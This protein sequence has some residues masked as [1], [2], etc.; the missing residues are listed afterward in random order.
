[1]ELEIRLEK[2][3]WRQIVDA[4]ECQ[5]VVY[6]DLLFPGESLKF[7]ITGITGSDRKCQQRPVIIYNHQHLTLGFRNI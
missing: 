5:T 4:F 3:G 2:V 6:I 1:M 7:F